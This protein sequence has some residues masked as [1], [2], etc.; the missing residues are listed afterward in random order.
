MTVE[1]VD[2]RAGTPH[3]SGD[4]LGDFKAGF[5]GSDGHVLKRGDNLAATLE[6]ANHITIATGSAIMP[7]SGRHVRVP[8]PET[9]DI[10][11]GTQGQKCYDLVVLRPVIPSNNTS[12][13]TAQIV[14][15]HGTP[16]SSTPVDPKYEE[17]DLPLYRIVKDGISVDAPIPLFDVL[18]PYAEF[19]SS[20]DQIPVTVN[21]FPNTVSSDSTFEC[22]AIPALNMCFIHAHLDKLK[23]NMAAGRA[24][25]AANLVDKEFLPSQNIDLHGSASNNVSISIALWKDGQVVIK[26]QGNSTPAGTTFSFSGFWRY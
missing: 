2:G 10:L 17:T 24:W 23:G 1:L 14:V 4:D 7:V 9:L 15:L 21:Y 25:T 19:R 20:M 11:S 16:T 8:A 3:I 26:S 6:D 22:Y 13:E 5:I 18:V 12:P